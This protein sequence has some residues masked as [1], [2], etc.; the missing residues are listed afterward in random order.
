MLYAFLD[1]CLNDLAN[2]RVEAG[3]NILSN[4]LEYTFKQFCEFC[5]ASFLA[6]TLAGQF[7]AQSR[8]LKGLI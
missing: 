3:V 1:F 8:H 5:N 7:L 4:F 6:G 2:H